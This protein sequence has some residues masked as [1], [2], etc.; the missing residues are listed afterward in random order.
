[1]INKME[2]RNSYEKYCQCSCGQIVKQ[3]NRFINGHNGR[4]KSK[5]FS[6][7]HKRKISETKKKQ[8]SLGLLYNPMDS[9]E[10]RKKL[11]EIR[12][13]EKN[14]FYGKNHSEEARLKMSI[15]HKGKTSGRKG[16]KQTEQWKKEH[17]KV[18]KEKYASGKLIAYW[19][20]KNLSIKHRESISKSLETAYVSGIRS[21]RKIKDTSI[22]LAFEKILKQLNLNYEKQYSIVIDNLYSCVDF[23]L[24][25]YNII[26]ECDGDYWHNRKDMIKQDKLKNQLWS[27]QGY[28]VLR[29]WEHAINDSI[30]NCISEL[31]AC[32]QKEDNKQLF[33][34]Y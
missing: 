5:F 25:D 32:L 30:N 3:G 7:E 16:K 34:F 23:F 21:I 18:L 14:P 4:G 9:E 27:L 6:E 12:K 20:D 31:C 2:K 28:T 33:N 19:K 26:I 1:M 13:G 17:S 15:A 29:F 8:H 10:T 11:S 22:E 24:P